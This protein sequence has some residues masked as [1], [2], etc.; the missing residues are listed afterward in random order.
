MKP[1]FPELPTARFDERDTMFARAAR[2]PGTDAYEEYYARRPELKEVDDALRAMPPLLD[3]AA[4]FHD[5]V[6][7]AEAERFFEEIPSIQPD[8]GFV[9]AWRERL[10]AAEDPSAAVKE[11]ALKLGAVA[12]GITAVDQAF[13]YSHKGRHDHH[14]GRPVR[15][16][17]RWA[18]VFLVEM[19]HHAMRCAPRAETIRESARQYYRSAVISLAIKQVLTECG[20][21]AESQHDAHYDVILPPLAVKAGLGQLGRN[22]I[23]LADRYGSRVRIGAVTTDL[24]L[25]P[26]APVDLGATFFCEICKKCA[27]NCPSKALSLGE[28]DVVRGVHKWP[29]D[30]ERCYGYWRRVGTDCGICMACCPFSHE[31]TAFHNFV[32]FMI[33]RSRLFAR[34]ALW[35][36]DL[37]YGRGWRPGS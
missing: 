28:R 1:P 6:L 12:A 5:P 26:D 16:T 9:A 23:L 4:V 14:Y 37:I 24:P 36:D 15:L 20:H 2:S 3:E 18:I 27:D 32:R 13:V 35:C 29:T 33:K 25:V 34:F 21:D 7:S 11:M 8:P 17:H 19:D 31:N 30:V 10:Q 22:N